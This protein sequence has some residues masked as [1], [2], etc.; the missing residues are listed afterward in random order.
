MMPG[1]AQ[2]YGRSAFAGFSLTMTA[3]RGALQ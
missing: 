1:K 2:T 3:A